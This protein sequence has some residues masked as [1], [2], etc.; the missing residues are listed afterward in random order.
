MCSCYQLNAVRRLSRG[1]LRH[2]KNTAP[3]ISGGLLETRSVT[4]KNLEIV[5]KVVAI[6]ASAS[7]NVAPQYSGEAT[8]NIR[9]HEHPPLS[10]PHS[11]PSTPFQL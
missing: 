6:K 10:L 4:H 11:Y 7:L 1:K 8:T 3:A 9:F 2:G 5:Y